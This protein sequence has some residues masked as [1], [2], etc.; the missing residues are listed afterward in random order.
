VGVSIL[1]FVYDRQLNYEVY[2]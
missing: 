2:T 1:V